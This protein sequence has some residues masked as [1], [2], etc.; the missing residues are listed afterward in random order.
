[1]QRYLSRFLTALA[2]VICCLPLAQA[3]AQLAIPKKPGAPAVVEEDAVGWLVLQGTLREGPLRQAWLSEQDAE[4]SL[5][6]VLEQIN[7]IKEDD[8]YLGLVVYLD[9]PA[10]TSTQI[11]A[12]YD[13]LLELRE[14]GKTVV[15]F[16]QAYSTPEYVL[17]SAGNIIALQRSG[18]VELT[19]MHIEEM[20]MAG[21]LEM[22]GI[23]PNFIQIGQYKG[24]SEQ[25]MRQGPSDAWSENM[26]GLLDGMYQAML[27]RIAQGRGLE[28]AQVEALME[29]SWTLNDEGLIEAGL[30]DQ[31]CGRDLTEVTEAVFGD[32]F[33]WDTEMGLTYDNSMS[34]A[35]AANPMMMIAALM[36]EPMVETDGPTIQV[37]HASGEIISGDSSYGD[38][39]FGGQSIGSRTI[40]QMLTDALYDD[41]VKAVV[42]R[43]DSPGGSALASEVMWQSIRTFGESKPIICSI[44]PMAASGGYYIASACDVIIVEPRAIVGSI[45]V[46]AG[47]L[48]LS[49]L[50]DMVGINVHTRSRGPNAGMLSSVSNFTDEERERLE[51]SMQMVYDQ[52]RDRVT[53]GRGNRLGDLDAVDEG[54]LFTGTQAVESGM[55]DQLGGL[56]D[57]IALAAE[58]ANLEPD[59][60]SLMELPHPMSL[61]AYVESLL[62]GPGL[63][64]GLSS[65]QHSAT[66][67]AARALVGE[68]AWT[69]ITRSLHGVTLLRDEQVLLLMPQTFV[70]E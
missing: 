67:S 36:Q 14:S 63:P 49:G 70:V 59:G 41:N 45:G 69:Q 16:A 58:Q 34:D 9:M 61:G 46:V 56:D 28:T 3:S 27:A 22:L 60:Y 19:G 64:M 2:L 42:L 23:Q 25:M 24:A 20:Y 17:A 40:D 51:A 21:L 15:T 33:V 62:A 68:N 4:P 8:H 32:D 31:L 30:V 11:D 18:S 35:I 53:V 52:F 12:I 1:M 47:K 50:Y 37:I 55:A 10:L 43:L 26:D 48:N 13:A 38:G 57:A 54:M 6:G 39:M 65:P 5:R 44:G 7:T 29:Q 66:L